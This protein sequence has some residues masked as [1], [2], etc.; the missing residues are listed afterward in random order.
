MSQSIATRRFEKS[1]LWLNAAVWLF[2]GLGYAVAPN[3]FA[4]LA[5]AAVTRADSYRI[6][7]DVGVMM[8][9]IG[10]WY[11]Y[12]ALDDSRTRH[13]LISAFLICVGMLVGRLIGMAAS[14]GANGVVMLYAALETLDSA[15]LLVALRLKGSGA[16]GGS[17]RGTAG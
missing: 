1:L 5:G 3:Y 8:L 10:I 17:L 4:S 9:G 2:F 6:M 16:G 14:G 7:A 15:L 11:V 13:G 12:C